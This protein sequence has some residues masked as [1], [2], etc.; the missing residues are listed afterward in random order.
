MNDDEILQNEY[1]VGDDNW[2]SCTDAQD[3]AQ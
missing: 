3:E 2:A 1:K